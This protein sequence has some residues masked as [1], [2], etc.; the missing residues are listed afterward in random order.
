M[1]VFRRIRSMQKWLLQGAM[2]NEQAEERHN[3]TYANRF[4]NRSCSSSY[5]SY[6]SIHG[7]AHLTFYKRMNH[8]VYCIE[9]VLPM[10][11]DLK[12]RFGHENFKIVHDNGN[13]FTC[14]KTQQ[15]LYHRGLLKFFKK[16]H[17]YSPD[18]NIIEN[19]WASGRKFLRL[20]MFLAE[21]SIACCSMH[22]VIY[23]LI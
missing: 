11:A 14:D 16:I 22:V 18:P 6:V 7:Q 1:R 23:L 8:K 21:S 20:V 17:A 13:F 12:Q 2:W 19:L 4:V 9:I 5:H 15:F 3:P 10:I